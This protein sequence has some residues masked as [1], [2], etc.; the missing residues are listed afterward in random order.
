MEYTEWLPIYNQILSDFNFSQESDE[1]SANVLKELLTS[2]KIIEIK[3][4]GNLISGKEV[5]IFGAG[6]ELDKDIDKI[7]ENNH[8]DF[9]TIAAD[10]ATSAFI[11]MGENPD[12]I[13]TDLDG[14]IPDQVQANKSGAVSIIHAHG[15][16]VQA[17]LE[18]VPKFEG[19]VLGTTQ[20]EPE[21][22]SNIF[23]FGGFTD[24]DRAVH[25][26]AHFKAKRIYLVSFNF[27]KIGKYSF[28]Y[29][30]K[31]KLRKLTWANLLIGMIKEPKIQFIPSD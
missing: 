18:W 14:Y 20:A 1:A 29:Q 23:N 30:S 7:F 26:A 22:N 25:L 11:K 9:V 19:Y 21:E 3:E 15:D 31:T 27:S 10:G 8:K 13:V 17:L 5:F 16:N 24:G 6:P 2:K 28:K 12:I 4:L